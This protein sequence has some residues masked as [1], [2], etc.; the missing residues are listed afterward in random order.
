MSVGLALFAGILA[1]FT[2]GVLFC[3]RGVKRH[4]DLAQ[5]WQDAYIDQLRELRRARF[6]RRRVV[7]VFEDTVEHLIGPTVEVED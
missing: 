3:Y 2:L 1:G 5:R 7:P 4:D 6:A